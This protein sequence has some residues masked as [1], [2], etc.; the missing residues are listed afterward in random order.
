[1]IISTKFSLRLTI[2]RTWKDILTIVIVNFIVFNLHEF[3]LEDIFEVPEVVP[4]IL[5]TAL[6]FFIG[7]NNNQAYDRWWESRKIWGSLVNDSRSWVRQLNSYVDDIDDSEEEKMEVVEK[8]T[9]RH[10]A[11]VYAL[12]NDL[13]KDGL[14]EYEKYLSEDELLKV[15]KESNIAN[16]ILNIQNYELSKI[17]KDKRIGDFQFSG[18]NKLLVRFTD[19]MGMSERI[20]NTVFPTSYVI[21]TRIFIWVLIL[22]TT[23]ELAVTQGVWSIFFGSAV[24][25]VFVTTHAIGIKILNPFELGTSGIPLNQISRTIEINMLQALGKKDIPSPVEPINGNYVL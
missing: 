23:Y 11:F 16:A 6:A 2:K 22:T 4:A 8:L 17:Y 25:Y 9:N 3:Y 15:K 5:G 14:R 1:M 24:G 7:F 21:F 19:E 18:L 10:I 13:R 20:K 12:K